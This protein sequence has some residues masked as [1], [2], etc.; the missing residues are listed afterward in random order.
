M[1]YVGMLVNVPR[2]L[3]SFSE[4]HIAHSVTT[5]GRGR[6]NQRKTRLLFHQ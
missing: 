3:N 6:I 5:H 1:P 4:Q 2:E